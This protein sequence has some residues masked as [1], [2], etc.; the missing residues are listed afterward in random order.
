MK[1][2]T[3][4]KAFNFLR[5]YF[6][7]LNEIPNKED[8][9]E[10]LLAII[11]KQFLDE[12][13]EELNFIVNLCYES[14]RHH[15]EESV[16]GW[17]RATNQTLK[18]TPQTPL[19][20]P[21]QTPSQE[22]EEKEEEKEKETPPTPKGDFDFDVYL[23]KIN[24]L[25]GKNL[26]LVNKKARQ[27]I[28]ARLKEGYTKGDIWNAMQNV[29]NDQWHKDNNYQYATPQYFSQVKTLDMHSHKPKEQ[30]NQIGGHTEYVLHD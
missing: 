9:L 13:P 2:L 30:K 18:D 26:R 19:M 10:Y 29:A 6:D 20:T 17:E 28:N 25:F 11:N 4:R 22:E 1:K 21:C 5:S 12:D 23:E 15:I 24:E 14:Q 27:S 3:K 16:K 7:V 8:K